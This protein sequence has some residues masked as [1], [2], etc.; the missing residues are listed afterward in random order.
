MEEKINKIN[1]MRKY[2]SAGQVWWIDMENEEGTKYLYEE[3]RKTRTWL[4]LSSNAEA[5]YCV[6]FTHRLNRDSNEPI[7]CDGNDK[8]NASLKGDYIGVFR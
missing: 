3:T 6:P 2:I 4:V 5:A 1:I 8:N 7:I